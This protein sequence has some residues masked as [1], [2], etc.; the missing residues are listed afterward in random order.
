MPIILTDKNFEEEIK[1][2]DKL[3]LVDFFATWCEP[4]SMLAPILD[5]VAEDMTGQIIL[6]KAN[7]DDIPITAQKFKVER[8]PTVVLFKNGE[9]AGGFVGLRQA[10]EIKK[11]LNEEIGK[12][13]KPVPEEDDEEKIKEMKNRFSEYAKSQGF[14]LNPDEKTVDRIIKG[15][16]ANEKKHGSQYCPCRRVTGD[17]EQDKKII[18]PCV[19]HKDEIA[20]DGKCFCGLFVK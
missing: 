14:R 4:C 20:K 6:A 17:K 16:L 3:V 5:E 10:D 7:L 19:Y 13:A 15:L 11:W 12:K 9:P 18:C 1:K 2:A 8:I